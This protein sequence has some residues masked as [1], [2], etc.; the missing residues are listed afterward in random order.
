MLDWEDVDPFYFLEQLIE[1][2]EVT[3]KDIEEW[4][5]LY[6]RGG[7]KP[8]KSY[9]YIA[10]MQEICIA[11]EERGEFLSTAELARRA[12]PTAK[13]ALIKKMVWEY[14]R[15]TMNRA[16]RFTRLKD[17]TLSTWRAKTSRSSDVQSK[18]AA[19]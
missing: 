19:E 12:E 2:R 15:L 7:P 3:L 10:A 11:A 4:L 16:L 9:K 5:R 14:N 1:E 6:K 17:G 13:A 18:L 8:P